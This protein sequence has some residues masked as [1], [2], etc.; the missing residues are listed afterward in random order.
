[1][2]QLGE[3]EGHLSHREKELSGVRGNLAT[4]QSQMGE[5]NRVLQEQCGRVRKVEGTLQVSG[6]QGSQL[7]NMRGMLQESHAVLAQAREAL[8]RERARGACASRS[9]AEEQQRSQILLELLRHFRTRVKDIAPQAMLAQSA[10]GLH[11]HI[12]LA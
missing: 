6:E 2:R 8:D 10:Q 4:V 12:T 7:L 5:L 9:L 3:K 11:H 1:M